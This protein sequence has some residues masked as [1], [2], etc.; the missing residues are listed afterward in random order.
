MAPQE[1]ATL[2]NQ[3]KKEFSKPSPDLS[4][5][6][7]LLAKLKVSIYSDMFRGNHVDG[8]T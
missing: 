6:G 1:L 4:K 5:C 3:L 2:Y 8:T 7:T